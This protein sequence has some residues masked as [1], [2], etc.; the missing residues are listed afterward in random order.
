VVLETAADPFA[1]GLL[2][3]EAG[4]V[5]HAFG[6]GEPNFSALEGLLRAHAAAPLPLGRR[7]FFGFA[8]HDHNLC[9]EGTARPAPGALEALAV[10]LARHEVRTAGE[11]AIL[12]AEPAR[13][14]PARPAPPGLRLVRRVGLAAS[15]RRPGG[16]GGAFDVQSGPR[17]LHARW[18]G[19]AQPRGVL[20][21]SHAGL[22]GGTAA[23]LTP[24]GLEPGPLLA[25]GLAVVA[26]DRSGTGRSPAAVPPTPGRDEHVEDFRAVLHAVRARLDPG[27]PV[28]ALSFSSGILPILGAGEPLAFLLD[29]EAPA[30]RM[31][32]RPPTGS[33]APEDPLLATL[34]LGDDL[35]WAGREPAR[36]L[37]SLA[38]P[39]HRLQAEYDHVH[40]RLYEHAAV[41]LAAARA[42]RCPRV[43][44]NGGQE[45]SLLEGHLHAHGVRIRGWILE[46]FEE[47]GGWRLE[48]GGGAGPRPGSG[49]D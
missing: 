24:F 19:P 40:G 46:A 10:F 11:L 26:Y 20:L 5:R 18:L 22:K 14:A 2:L 31:S 8:L 36:L 4:G 6:V 48:A 38:C 33:G 23:L 34:P 43:R 15:A 1:W 47:A 28:G 41:M 17:R 44:C 29:G 12:G 30:D 13:F 9:V 45:M 39:Y 7:G 27:V 37:G 49:A 3:R 21:L 42:G 32:L 35:A 25:E 16:P